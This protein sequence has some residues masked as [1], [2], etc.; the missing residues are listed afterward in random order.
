MNAQTSPGPAGHGPLCPQSGNA[1]DALVECGYDPERVEHH[2]RAR[3]EWL[4][5]LLERLHRS[6]V[7]CCCADQSVRRAMDRIAAARHS[8]AEPRLSEADADALEQLVTRGWDARRVPAA[9]RA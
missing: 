3:C 8:D 6:S 4:A 5:H 9:L 2:H 7:P 1:V